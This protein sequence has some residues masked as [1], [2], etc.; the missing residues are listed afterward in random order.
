MGQP[1]PLLSGA[2][3]S[4]AYIANAQRCV[5]VFPE[6]NPK[7]TD[8]GTPVTHLAR[9]G[10]VAKGAP[11]IVAPGRV[12]YRSTRGV[13]DP[14]GDLFCVLGQNVYF[15][16]PNWAYTLLGQLATPANTPVSMADNGT[17]IL[18]VDNSANGYQIALPAAGQTYTAA[19]FTQIGDPN[20]LGSTRADLLNSIIILNRPGTNQ[21][22]CTTPGAITPFNALYIGVKTAWSDNIRCVVANEAEVLVLGTQKSEPWYDAGA[23]PFPFQIV[24]QAIIEQ[25]C[26][27]AYSV[28][29]NDAFVYWLSQDPKGARMAMKCGAANVAQRISNHGVE[30]EWLKYARVDD[31]IA[32]AYQIEGHS[33]IRFTFPAADKTWVFDE[34]TQQWW[35]DNWMDNNGALHRARN[36]FC[37]YAYG[38]NLGLDWSTGQLYHINLEA[39][40]DAGQPIPWVRSYPHQVI[41]LHNVSMAAFIADVETG[42][43]EAAGEAT[44]F[45]SP[46]SLGFN[47]GFG[48]VT[49]LEAPAVFFRYSKDG[50]NKFSNVRSHY[51]LSAGRYRRIMRWRD[52]G[53]GRDWV[54]EVSSTKQMS[55]ALQGGFCDPIRA[56]A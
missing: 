26:V 31:V 8:P 45:L 35:E 43:D 40:T 21:W 53:I 52:L 38:K 22:Y 25:G 56:A 30:Q 36:T 17:D 46:W 27:A 41:E 28:E 11:P 15:I 5:N 12:L 23:V 6:I 4:A 55:K 14:D 3:E 13:I 9:P 10:L 19:S 54:F 48:P 47:A 2:Y 29:K 44:Q 20:F 18:I 39:E 24:P 32:S 16:D 34:A 7:E 42:T 1:I 51:G 50:G 33:F 37:A 49:E